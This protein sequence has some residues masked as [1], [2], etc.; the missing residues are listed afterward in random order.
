MIYDKKPSV[1]SDRG[2]I[3]SAEELDAY[4]VWVKSEPQDLVSDL[5]EAAGFSNGAVPYES[6]EMGF[7][8]PEG[9]SVQGDFGDSYADD[10]YTESY[11]DELGA[12]TIGATVPLS[13]GEISNELLLK[14]SNELSSIRSELNIL[15]N[16]FA[17]IRAETGAALHTRDFSDDTGEDEKITLTPAQHSDFFDDADEDEKITLTGDELDN[18]LSSANLSSEEFPGDELVVHE[19]M[20]FDPLREED[21][22]ALKEL[23]EQ[24]EAF[25]EQDTAFQDAIADLDDSEKHEDIE[26]IEI[27]FDNLGMNLTYTEEE[28]PPLLSLDDGEETSVETST[29][30]SEF[31]PLPLEESPEPSFSVS[32]LDEVTELTEGDTFNELSEEIVVQEDGEELRELRLEGAS[33]ITFPPEDSTYLEDD[34]S[35]DIISSITTSDEEP[36]DAPIEQSETL[37]DHPLDITLDDGDFDL[38]LDS[39]SDE[40]VSAEQMTDELQAEEIEF[41]EL[42]GQELELPLENMEEASIDLSS[43]IIDEPDLSTEI[44]E[45]PLE[46]PVLEDVSLSMD[47]FDLGHDFDNEEITDEVPVS[48]DL[49]PVAEEIVSDDLVAEEILADDLVIEE[50]VSEDIAP[51]AEE[52]VL[53]DVPEEDIAPVTEEIVSDDLVTEEIVME[54]LSPVDDFATAGF[55]DS[56]LDAKE[57]DFAVDDLGDSIDLDM[58]DDNLVEVDNLVTDDF[59]ASVA[60]DTKDEGL[61]APEIIP[62]GFEV[63]AEEAAVSLDDDLEV[64]TEEELPLVK[65]E[66]EEPSAKEAVSAA[67]EP[68]IPSGMK[69]DL[70]KVLSY[71]DHLLESLPEDKIEEF[72]KSE[73]FDAYKKLFKDLGLA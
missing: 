48:D 8:I 4:G 53:E 28:V 44:V 1:Y 71:M 2:T 29:F 41:S 37:E 35:A 21:E 31:E 27:D 64:F 5:A 16:E 55:A 30:D 20:D 66:A 14:I 33:P 25:A 3:G 18:I 32:E 26:D 23:S 10:S 13:S 40:N 36:L 68:S 43:A 70:K 57:I 54:D 11:E 59:E 24:N 63:N 60:R 73:Y 49:A 52:V 61:L 7:D 46:E 42:Q 50:V 72:A 58:D 65:L 47:D 38:S 34:L 39:F 69:T 51:V 22:A 56:D 15:K 17:E 45:T 67:S 6:Y 12:S 62:E 19:D 9:E